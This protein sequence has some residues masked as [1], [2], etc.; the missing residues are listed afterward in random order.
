MREVGLARIEDRDAVHATQRRLHIAI[1]L[2]RP[3]GQHLTNHPW[4]R[5]YPPRIM[6]QDHE[7]VSSTGNQR[8]CRCTHMRRNFLWPKVA[9]QHV[10][11]ADQDG[12]QMRGHRHR[13]R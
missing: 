7:N 11:S 2:V 10:V 12:S 1:D 3:F 6:Q 9:A 8:R 13:S 4:P 5:G